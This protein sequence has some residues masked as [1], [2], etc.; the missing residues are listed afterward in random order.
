[1]WKLGVGVF[2]I[3]YRNPMEFMSYSI[4]KYVTFL[5]STERKCHT[6]SINALRTC[7]LVIVSHLW[8]L[9]PARMLQ[10]QKRISPPSNSHLIYSGTVTQLMSHVKPHINS[11]RNF[12]DKDWESRLRK[13]LRYDLLA[14]S[15]PTF[16]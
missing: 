1:M 12:I 2:I 10:L 4:V 3:H 5:V 15:L 14:E 11:H 6:C 7:T 13:R 16:M 9:Q 8:D